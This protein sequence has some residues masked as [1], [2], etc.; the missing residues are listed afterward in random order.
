[1]RYGKTLLLAALAGAL[2]LGVTSAIA[3]TATFA[4]CTHMADQVATA[5]KAHMDAPGYRTAKADAD[6]GHAACAANNY[7]AGVAYYQKALTEIGQK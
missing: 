4:T 3:G 6:N 7:D 2:S 5:L 1:M